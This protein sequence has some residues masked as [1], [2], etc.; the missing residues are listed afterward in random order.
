MKKTITIVQVYF[1]TADPT[2][3]ADVEDLY[4]ILEDTLETHKSELNYVI[5]DFNS[6]VGNLEDGKESVLGLYR[7]GHRNERGDRLIQFAF[8]Q[9]MKIVNT[10]FKKRTSRKW[11]HRS[12]DGTFKTEIDYML[13]KELTS[14]KNFEVLN[15]FKFESDHR[16]MRMTITISG[17]KDRK[18]WFKQN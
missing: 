10:F 15:Q 13:T 6:R 14:V 16:L 1:P 4:D 7:Y 12:P 9:Q 18:K 3:D 2:Y 11:T 5:G 8:G 17:L